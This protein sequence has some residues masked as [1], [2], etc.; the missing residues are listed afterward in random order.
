MEYACIPNSNE[1]RGKDKLIPRM[2]MQ[3]NLPSLLV[4]VPS[5]VGVDGSYLI[6]K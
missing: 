5:V 1:M 2:F 6:K 4:E 3:D